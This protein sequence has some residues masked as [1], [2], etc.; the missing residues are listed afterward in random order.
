MTTEFTALARQL[1]A[2]QD[3][4]TLAGDAECKALVKIIRRRYH[5]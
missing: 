5:E 1:I 4:E 3:C 2:E